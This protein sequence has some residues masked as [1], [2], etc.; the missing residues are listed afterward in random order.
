M[1]QQ[2]KILASVV[3]LIAVDGLLQGVDQGRETA[4]LLK[5]AGK[6]MHAH[7]GEMRGD[8]HECRAGWFLVRASHRT[9]RATCGSLALPLAAPSVEMAHTDLRVGLLLGEMIE[10]DATWAQRVLVEALPNHGER[11]HAEF[12]SRFQRWTWGLEGSRRVQGE[13]HDDTLVLGQRILEDVVCT[14]A[15][16]EQGPFIMSM[17]SRGCMQNRGTVSKARY[18]LVFDQFS[19]SSQSRHFS[20]LTSLHFSRTSHGS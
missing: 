2:G 14:I 7:P 12:S 9:T 19:G 4:L 16:K 15:L 13:R 20:G 17:K 1:M 6:E 10:Q 3:A 11:H 5:P 8:L 18:R